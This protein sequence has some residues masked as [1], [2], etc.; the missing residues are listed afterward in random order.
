MDDWERALAEATDAAASR[1]RLEA[2]RARTKAKSAAN[3]E[4]L[5]RATEDQ[6]SQLAKEA[7]EVLKARR[8]HP[9]VCEPA[10]RQFKGWSVNHVEYEYRRDGADLW[11]STKAEWWDVYSEFYAGSFSHKVNR[12]KAQVQLKPG[13]T[14]ETRVVLSPPFP[15]NFTI[16]NKNDLAEACEGLRSRVAEYVVKH[17]SRP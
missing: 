12:Y 7:I 4:R 11:L 9:Q 10:A 14:G 5:R 2:A 3:V 15:G 16:E 13:V 8:I 6:L 1:R 17:D